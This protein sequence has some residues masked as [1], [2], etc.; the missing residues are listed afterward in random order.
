[1]A[2][3]LGIGGGMIKAPLMLE[4]G[5]L[6]RVARVTSL[7]MILFTS[8]STVLQYYLLGRRLHPRGFW[9]AAVGFVGAAV[10]HSLFGY[11]LRTR[12]TSLVLVPLS[13]V[14]NRTRI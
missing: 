9:F 6:P 12:K 14:S 4:L 2:G 8:S 7:F 3:F 5:V 10:G 11:V 1:M 13:H